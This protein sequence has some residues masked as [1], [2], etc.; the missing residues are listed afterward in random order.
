MLVTV[1]YD[2]VAAHSMPYHWLMQGSPILLACA[3]VYER[4]R[5]RASIAKSDDVLPLTVTGPRRSSSGDEQIHQ[6]RTC[7]THTIS[8]PIDLSI[9]LLIEP[10]TLV[11]RHGLRPWQ[12][13]RAGIRR[14]HPAR[15]HRDAIQSCGL[16]A[17]SCD[18]ADGV[19]DGE[20]ARNHVTL[21]DAREDARWQHWIAVDINVGGSR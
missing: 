20:L 11:W 12:R 6:C 16:D 18:R 17:V 3:S 15:N 4:E 19:R 8:A 10:R 7:E 5:D 9:N 13:S 14:P 2:G 1:L 21:G